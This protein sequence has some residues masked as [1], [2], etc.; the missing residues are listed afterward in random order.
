[1]Q[2]DESILGK[3]SEDLLYELGVSVADES[4]G[5]KTKSRM[6]FVFDALAWMSNR[7]AEFISRICQSSVIAR[8]REYERTSN[9]LA[10]IG[11]IAD[12]VCYCCGTAPVMTVSAL[13]ADEG[14]HVLCI[15]ECSDEHRENKS[16][17]KP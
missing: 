12:L 14:L 7:R 15:S 3:S 10:L 6:D 4:L 13:L 8:L 2:I 1:M 17:T 16:E 11:A 5:S 9:R